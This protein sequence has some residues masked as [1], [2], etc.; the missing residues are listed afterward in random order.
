MG[1]LVNEYTMLFVPYLAIIQYI[2]AFVY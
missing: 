1:T 2:R